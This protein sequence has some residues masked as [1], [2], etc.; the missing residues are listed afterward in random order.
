MAYI[1]PRKTA[2]KYPTERYLNIIKKGYRD[3]KLEKKYLTRA[4]NQI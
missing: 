4:L 2:F 3:C 1:M